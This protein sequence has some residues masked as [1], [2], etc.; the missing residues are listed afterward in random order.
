MKEA[1]DDAI[2]R[3]E[4]KFAALVDE[5]ERLRADRLMLERELH[6]VRRDRDRLAAEHDRLA[7][8]PIEAETSVDGATSEHP[9]PPMPPTA[10]TA[11]APPSD[12][13][14]PSV[15][16]RRAEQQR[17]P[18]ATVASGVSDAAL[19]DADWERLSGGGPSSPS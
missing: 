14:E 17:A 6:R 8:R 16:G 3:I 15:D 2:A 10:S 9:R 4:T 7:A 18:S 13:T 1:A 19:S 12:L 5:V 11:A